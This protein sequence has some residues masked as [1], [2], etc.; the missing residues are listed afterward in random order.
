MIIHEGLNIL[1]IPDC[2]NYVSKLMHYKSYPYPSQDN[3]CFHLCIYKHF[4]RVLIMYLKIVSFS[5]LFR[6]ILRNVYF[7]AKYKDY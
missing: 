2:M 3:V 4:V 5:I 1:I 7:H 6:C